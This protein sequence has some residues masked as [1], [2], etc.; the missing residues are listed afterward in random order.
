M[1][2]FKVKSALV[3][4]ALLCA[5]GFLTSGSL[6]A[7]APQPQQFVQP[8]TPTAQPADTA[9]PR[10]I[11]ESE[12]QPEA[13]SKPVLEEEE[14][15]PEPV[16]RRFTLTNDDFPSGRRDEVNPAGSPLMVAMQQAIDNKLGVRYRYHGQDDSGYD[17]SGFVWSVFRDVGINF[18]RSSAADYYYTFREATP[19]ERSKFGT[20]IF[21]NNLGHIGIVKDATHFYHASTKYGITLAKREG[22]WE[23]RVTG[24]RT[25][26][27]SPDMPLL[28]QVR[29]ANPATKYAT[30][31]VAA[32]STPRKHGGSRYSLH[33][34]TA[35][36]GKNRRH[37]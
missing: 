6:F 30:H 35:K 36:T 8:A 14:P 11:A 29:T 2:T 16:R 25:V 9:R 24:Y 27:M 18:T 34:S 19:E 5:A 33:N 37:R 31:N 3:S 10:R 26:L 13:A 22:Y 23:N 15:A 17:C 32:K 20:L 28:A 12:P 1:K 7:Q 21:F 4:S